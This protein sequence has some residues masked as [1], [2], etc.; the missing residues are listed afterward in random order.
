MSGSGDKFEFQLSLPF[1]PYFNRLIYDKPVVSGGG[2]WS[3]GKNYRK[4]KLS[5]LQLAHIRI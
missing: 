3:T 1:Q 4:P 2:N 5:H